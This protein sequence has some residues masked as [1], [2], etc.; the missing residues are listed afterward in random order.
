MKCKHFVRAARG[1]GDACSQLGSLLLKCEY[2]LIQDRWER[3]WPFRWSSLRRWPA[4]GIF[5]V[6]CW[7]ALCVVRNC[8]VRSGD[9]SAADWRFRA[10]ANGLVVSQLFSE[11]NDINEIVVFS[12]YWT[13]GDNEQKNSNFN[14]SRVD[15]NLGWWLLLCFRPVRGVPAATGGEGR[16]IRRYSHPHKIMQLSNFHWMAIRTLCWRL[17]IAPSFSPTFAFH[18]WAPVCNSSVKCTKP[19]V[20]WQSV[21][22]WLTVWRCNTTSHEDDSVG[23]QCCGDPPGDDGTLVGWCSV[24]YVHF[25]SVSNLNI[26]RKFEYSDD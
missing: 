24:Q 13:A 15:E 11:W 19:F 5:L 9:Y 2:W 23:G 26:F 10:E 12:C 20:V 18:W 17:T 14:L 7:P 6:F 21:T 1:G 22:C 16:C 3:A 25:V 4:G 8:R